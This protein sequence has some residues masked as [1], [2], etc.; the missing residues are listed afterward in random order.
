MGWTGLGALIAW[1][2]V[3]P[4]HHG[5]YLHW[6]SHEHMPERLAIPGF[7]R[8]RRY[9]VVGPGP[10]FLIIY[11]VTDLEVFATPAYLERLNNP[12]DWT[13]RIMPSLWSMNRSLC[14][15]EASDG[16]GVGRFMLTIQF[17]PAPG[18]EAALQATLTEEIQALVKG[19]GLCA[20]HLLMADRDKSG[21]PTRERSLRTGPDT[22]ADW[23]LL[24]EGYDESAVAR[25]EAN[26]LTAGADAIQSS[27]YLIDQVVQQS[28][29][30]SG[31][32]R[33]DQRAS[34]PTGWSG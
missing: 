25:P 26:L 27:L 18:Q 19:E 10:Q 17:S 14:R 4:G 6:H 23:V 1:H 16:V 2:D 31:Q 34:E 21:T 33:N 29:L 13:R 20:A 24:I 32:V 7:L 5:K 8:G 30:P 11:E 9:S 3:E 15:V 28:D 12:T 22:I